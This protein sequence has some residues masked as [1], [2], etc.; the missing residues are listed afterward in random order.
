MGRCPSPYWNASLKSPGT[1][2]C[3]LEDRNK[4]CPLVHH[5]VCGYQ[6]DAT[7]R[8]TFSD[9]CR[10]CSEQRIVGYSEGKCPEDYVPPKYV[11]CPSPG[12]QVQTKCAR[13]P[14]CAIP[15][16]GL[17][18][19][20]RSSCSVCLSGKYRA[21]IDG[22]CSGFIKKCPAQRIDCSPISALVRSCAF[23]TRKEPY[24]VRL[25]VCC[26]GTNFESVLPLPC[27]EKKSRN[28]WV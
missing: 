9:E 27:P 15:F 4:S 19:D 6:S 17:P 25:D 22:S 20:F 11:Y 10:A 26:Q 21:Y 18:R 16:V 7:T 5:W 14:I 1:T 2:Q 13:Q 24:N 23:E 28:P 3:Q 12:A 8:Q